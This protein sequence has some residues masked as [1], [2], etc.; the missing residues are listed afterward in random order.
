M[1]SMMSTEPLRLD[2]LSSPPLCLRLFLKSSLSTLPKWVISLR[3]L[4]KL[5]LQYSNLSDDPLKML[6]G[7][8]NLVVLEL[9]EAYAGEELC[10][11]F[12]GYS[13]LKNLVRV[14]PRQL[15]CI[16]V[17]QGAMPGLRD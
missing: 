4:D 3:Y 8:P 2:S 6:Q 13:K 5:V 12:G 15:K 10:C 17:E 9:R 14:H 1:V 16:K 11:N 7:M